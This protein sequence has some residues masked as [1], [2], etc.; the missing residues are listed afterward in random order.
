MNAKF[1]YINNYVEKKKTKEKMTCKKL[2][3]IGKEFEVTHVKNNKKLI[4]KTM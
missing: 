2:N 1:F 4:S 3:R